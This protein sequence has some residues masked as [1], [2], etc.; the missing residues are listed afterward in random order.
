MSIDGQVLAGLTAVSVIY[1]GYQQINIQTIDPVINDKA[2][3]IVKS[4]WGSGLYFLIDFSL[5]F[6][7]QNV[8]SEKPTIRL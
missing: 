7:L 2:I 4:N 8:H 3:K 5:N 6:K 1:T